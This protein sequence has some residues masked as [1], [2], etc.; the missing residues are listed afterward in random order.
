MFPLGCEGFKSTL[1]L[2]PNSAGSFSKH[3][4]S[5]QQSNFYTTSLD[6][7]RQGHKSVLYTG[8]FDVL[9]AEVDMYLHCIL[10]L[11]MAKV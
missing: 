10:L 8:H 1:I 5:K 7:I 3:S 9:Q 6:A 4:H 2:H 11:G